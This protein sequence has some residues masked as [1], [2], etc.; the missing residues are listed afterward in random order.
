MRRLLCFGSLLFL[1]L[2][3]V[4]VSKGEGHE[5]ISRN[6]SPVYKYLIS[7]GF[8]VKVSDFISELNQAGPARLI[9]EFTMPDEAVPGAA[10][11]FDLIG[12]HLDKISLNGNNGNN[13][14]RDDIINNSTI[15]TGNGDG[16]SNES[17]NNNG[18]NVLGNNKFNKID[19]NNRSAKGDIIKCSY[20]GTNTSNIIDDSLSNGTSV[21]K[22]SCNPSN[23]VSRGVSSKNNDIKSNS[24]IESRIITNSNTTASNNISTTEITDISKERNQ[25]GSVLSSSSNNTSSSNSS[26]SSSSNSSNSSSRNS[27]SSSSGSSST[28]VEL[29]SHEKLPDGQVKPGVARS[30]VLDRAEIERASKIVQ[31]QTQVFAKKF[32]A[33]YLRNESQTTSPGKKPEAQSTM[34]HVIELLFVVDY[35]LY[36]TFL[37]RNGFNAA[38]TL[39]DIQTYYSQVL[40]AT[41]E[42]YLTATSGSF[43]VTLSLSGIII[44]ETVTSSPWTELFKDVQGNVDPVIASPSFSSFALGINLTI[45][46]DLAVLFTGYDLL[47]NSVTPEPGYTPFAGL[48]CSVL[49]VV[50]VQDTLDELTPLNLARFSARSIGIQDDGI[51]GCSNDNLNVMSSTGQLPVS[52][53][54]ASNPWAFSSCSVTE[55]VNQLD[56][57][58]LFCTAQTSNVFPFNT[59]VFLGELF[60]QRYDADSQCA[61][62]QRPVSRFCRGPIRHGF[63]PRL[64][65]SCLMEGLKA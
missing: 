26:S 44:A 65:C 38:S 40:R 16:K 50:W 21:N 14:S 17:N 4:R 2:I 58:A 1:L 61:N 41:N 54:E 64:R 33:L 29:D 35:I 25:S 59:A 30:G 34:S 5:N 22:S 24:S 6:Q 43:S 42:R 39:L 49:G 27:N 36:V 37:Q 46:H 15:I 28:Q 52:S 11:V 8:I 32:K 62:T 60:G 7:D 55:L 9:A 63:E 12:R 3:V 51:N 18:E 57:Q 13:A 56:N 53:A 23:E 20:A 19:D 31:Q 10:A 47:I 45:P 48:L